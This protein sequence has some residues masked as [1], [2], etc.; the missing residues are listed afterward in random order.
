[1]EL[2]KHMGTVDKKIKHNKKEIVELTASNAKLRE[3][4]NDPVD[5]VGRCL[6]TL[7]W[8]DAHALRHAG[9]MQR[10]RFRPFIG[11]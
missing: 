5:K 8:F 7:A 6:R 3:T 11:H 2:A 9:R 10:S 1:M 4:L